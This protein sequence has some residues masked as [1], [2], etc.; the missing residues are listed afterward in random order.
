MAKIREY[1]SIDWKEHFYYDLTSETGLRRS[2]DWR[3]G[4]NG[5]ILKGVSGDVAG[6]LNSTSGYYY[7]SLNNK[8]YLCHRVIFEIHH[9]KIGNMFVDH[10][11][12][13]R[14]NNCIENLRLTTQEVNNRN[15]VMS[16]YNTSG[17]TGVRKNIS[18]D[19]FRVKREVWTAY[20]KDSNGR[21]IV[22][23]FS[24]VKL[25]ND[26]AFEE[27]CSCRVKMLLDRNAEGAGYTETHGLK[28]ETE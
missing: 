11:D 22:K 1:E 17:V 9:G 18:V 26:I 21:M 19:K 16:K 12:R 2:R 10:I 7:V 15:R 24:I 5:R 13:N 3:S 27:A 20:C 8:S 6:G 23:Y 25:G 4:E 28:E 14:A